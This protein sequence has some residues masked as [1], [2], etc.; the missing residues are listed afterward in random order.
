VVFKLLDEK[1]ISDN[2]KNVHYVKHVVNR[3]EYGD[4]SKI[5][6]DDYERIAEELQN[7]PIDN[8]NIFGYI[9]RDPTKPSGMQLSSVKYNKATGDYVSYAPINGEQRTITLFKRDWDRFK[10]LRVKEYYADLPDGY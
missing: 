10:K 3:L 8:V 5:S 1:F 6:P 9:K 2:G 4:P 7:S